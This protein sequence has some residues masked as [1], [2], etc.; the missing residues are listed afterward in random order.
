[1]PRCYSGIDEEAQVAARALERLDERR[2]HGA[3]L[4]WISPRRKK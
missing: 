1:M 3:S 2:F 4:L